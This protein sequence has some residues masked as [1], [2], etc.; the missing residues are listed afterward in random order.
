MSS[1]KP[2]GQTLVTDEL[3]VF[4]LAKLIVNSEK[5]MIDGKRGSGWRFL[6]V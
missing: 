3:N 6:D 2:L 1:C 4:L 5:K